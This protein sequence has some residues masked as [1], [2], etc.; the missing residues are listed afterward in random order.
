MKKIFL[1]L[2]ILYHNDLIAGGVI[3]CGDIFSLPDTSS[4]TKIS[5]HAKAQ[6]RA[7]EEAEDFIGKKI[8]NPYPNLLGKKDTIKVFSK[9][10]EMF[11][12]ESS[13]IPL[14]SAY[15]NFYMRNKKV[16]RK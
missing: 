10:I 2:I 13:T 5:L 6:K 9:I 15:Y 12:C 8:L 1:L 4:E 11:W 16:W 7:Q 3:T 14:H